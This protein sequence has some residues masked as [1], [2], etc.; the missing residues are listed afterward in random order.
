MASPGDE[1]AT[2]AASR[3][4]MRASHA[5]REQ[6]IDM[7]KTAFVH[8]RLTRDELDARMG[9]ALAARTHA[10]LAALTADIPPAP[11]AVL[12]ERPPAPARRRPLA[13]AAAKSGLCLIITAAFIGGRLPLRFVPDACPGGLRHVG[14]A[15]H[16][17]IRGVHRMGREV[18]PRAAAAP[19]GAG[20][21][22][23]RSRTARRHRPWPGSPRP[24]HR[25]DRRLPADS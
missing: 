16:H 12:P 19:A 5:D 23:P 14:G 10:D 20:R 18:L 21:P 4:R 1:M 15:R 7:L 13:G 11:A 25:P 24:S 3:G 9:R 8:G 6:V 2:G 17:G 22:G